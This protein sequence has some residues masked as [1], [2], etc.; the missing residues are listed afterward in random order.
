MYA[1]IKRLQD[2]PKKFLHELEEF[3]V[4]YHSLEGKK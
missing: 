3:F 2:L 1:N 4:N